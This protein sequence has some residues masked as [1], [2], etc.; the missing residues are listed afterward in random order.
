MNGNENVLRLKV[1]S[2]IIL[3]IGLVFSMSGT[4]LATS[5]SLP[6]T[7]SWT[8]AGLQEM[9]RFAGPI[10]VSV[11]GA[12]FS[13][14]GT[15]QVSKPANSTVI[16]AYLTSAVTSSSTTAPGVT[17]NGSAVTF[18]HLATVTSG[19]RFANHF[20]DVTSIVKSTI[21]T[22]SSGLVDIA[23]SE[24]TGASTNEGQSLIVVFDD[25]AK[26][27]S[28]VIIMFGASK[29]AGDSFSFSFPAITDLSAQIPTLSLGIGY[30]YQSSGSRT[31]QSDVKISTSTNTSLQTISLTAGS[32]DD[33]SGANGALLTVG[34]VGDSPAL[35]GLTATSDDDE[36]YGLGSFLS[37]GDTTL[38][39]NTRNASGDDNLFLSV[40]YFE[41]VS[42][43]GAV[44]VGSAPVVFVG[45]A[46]PVVS[47][48]APVEPPASV[49]PP[50]EAAPATVTPVATPTLA[51]TGPGNIATQILVGSAIGLLSLGGWLV[52]VR[53]RLR[54]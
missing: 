49:T 37:L 31:Q 9:V 22:A 26:P 39:V 20:A 45:S 19:T 1:L 47:P 40:L 23:V 12:G 16:A 29:S 33:G 8:N 53:R 6:S 15:L 11:D 17:L 43:A 13:T 36:L 42:V 18:S 7:T 24:S 51:T 54:A 46:P 25:P 5:P 21:D 50:V 28:S 4:A 44:T 38:S 35:P 14:S 34:G 30:S 2:G 3:S 10:S 27:A 32:F 48:P 52:L 41:G